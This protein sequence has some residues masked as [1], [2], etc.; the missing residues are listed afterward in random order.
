[1]ELFS[2]HA[3]LLA[4]LHVSTRSQYWAARNWFP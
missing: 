3:R 2:Q 4:C 1:M